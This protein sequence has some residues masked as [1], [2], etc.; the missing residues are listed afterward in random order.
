[1]LGGIAAATQREG[2]PIGACG[3]ASGWVF[4]RGYGLHFVAVQ[5]GLD[6][7]CDIGAEFVVINLSQRSNDVLHLPSFTSTTDRIVEI[8]QSLNTPLDLWGPLVRHSWLL[9]NL[10]LPAAPVMRCSQRTQRRRSALKSS[11]PPRKS[12]AGIQ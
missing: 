3:V 8:A 6:R 12:T 2:W 1:M 9:P 11:P 10:E 4:R 5:K 7:G